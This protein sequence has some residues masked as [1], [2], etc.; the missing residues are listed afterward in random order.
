MWFSI[1]VGVPYIEPETQTLSPKRK[2][3]ASKETALPELLE[4]AGLQGY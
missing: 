3:A 1:G 2:N 4:Q